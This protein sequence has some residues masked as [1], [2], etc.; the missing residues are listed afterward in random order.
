MAESSGKERNSLRLKSRINYL[1]LM[2]ALV[3]AGCGSSSIE[4]PNRPETILAFGDSLTAGKGT[5]KGN[6][7]PEVLAR[8]TGVNVIN[9]GISGET[10]GEGRQ[11]LAKELDHHQPDLLILM[12]GGN[13][14][15]RNHRPQE[16]RD[17]LEAMIK[18]SQNR[19]IPVVLIG[20][21]QKSLFSSS[22]PLYSE[23]ADKYQLV[24]D[25]KLIAELLRSPALKSDRV[26]F[27]TKGYARMAESIY[28]V[29][30]DNGIF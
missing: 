11:R 17:N 12:E 15:L 25:G 22:A 6:S 29:M 27:N 23:L 9:A 10:T 14:I 19:E 16:I 7:Y 13:D 24:F 1:F 28:E 26:H 4:L 30:Q 18:M 8:L 2:L 5:S 3:L 21:P 20:I